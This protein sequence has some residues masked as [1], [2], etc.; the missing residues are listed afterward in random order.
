MLSIVLN[1]RFWREEWWCL[2]NDRNLKDLLQWCSAGIGGLDPGDGWD[3]FFYPFYIFLI[4]FIFCACVYSF[5]F[6]DT[7]QNVHC[8]QEWAAHW[9]T[10]CSS[11]PQ[12]DASWD[13]TSANLA[14]CLLET[15]TLHHKMDNAG[16]SGALLLALQQQHDQLTRL[17]TLHILKT[18]PMWNYTGDGS[19][20][21]PRLVPSYLTF[22]L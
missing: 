19:K 10:G 17:L 15:G 14:W 21:G 8:F 3:P 1:E 6:L 4:I 5:V 22:D 7:H 13:R 18:N 2:W 11:E 9:A 20:K 16:T 12:S